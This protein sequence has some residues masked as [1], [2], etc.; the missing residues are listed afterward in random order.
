VK[1]YWLSGVVCCNEKNKIK[2]KERE[3]LE[4]DN[5]FSHKNSK[6]TGRG[7]KGQTIHRAI[8]GLNN[9]SPRGGRS[10]SHKQSRT[11]G[12]TYFNYYWSVEKFFLPKCPA[13]LLKQ[14][15]LCSYH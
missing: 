9:N 15:V 8:A 4:K 6:K 10:I 13:V 7:L 14:I 2:K 1:T 3:Q 11:Q 5:C 12:Q